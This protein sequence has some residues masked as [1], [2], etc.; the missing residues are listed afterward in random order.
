M[1]ITFGGLA[2][3]LDT[4]SIV[5]QLMAIE[6]Q[7]IDRLEKDREWFSSRQT[8]YMTFD[9]KLREFASSIKNLG[10]SDDLLQKSV[11]STSKDYVSVNATPEAL[12]GSS[13]QVEVVSL[14][15]VQKDVSRGYA[16]KMASSFGTGDLTLAVGDD[17]AV[18]I[19]I[20]ETNNSL[21]GVMQAINAADAGVSAAIINDGTDSPYRLVLTGENVATDFSL[22]SN[23]STFDGDLSSELQ[24]GGFPHEDTPLFGSGTLDLSTGDQITLSNTTNSLTDIMEA[25]NAESDTTGVT[26]EIVADGDNFVLSLSGG[27]TITATDLSGGDFVPLSLSETQAATRAHVRVDSID[28]YA[29]SNTLDEAIPGLA[30]DLLKAEEGTTTV[31]SVAVD[32]SAVKSQI[33]SFVDGYNTVASFISS[34]STINGSSG[35]ILNGDSGVNVVKRRLQNL[36]TTSIDN[37]GSFSALSQLGLKTERD[38]TLVLDDEMLT[39]AIRNNLEGVE[40]LLVGEDGS[41]GIAVKFQ[42]YLDDITDSTDGILAGTKKST[43]SNLR[44]IDNRI[45]QMEMR[46]AHREETMRAK[47]TAMESLVS[48]LNSQSDFLTQ[49]MDLLNNM[50]TGN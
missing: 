20:D 30:L 44:R 15:Q 42:D 1:S 27:A 11:T 38:G 5:E 47:Y 16:D 9:N 6:R 39:N 10:S 31:V 13:Y 2:T 32:E 33:Q 34:Q 41:D 37:S 7:P 28:I 24:S 21:Y 25:I 40:K 50:M 8:A 49:Q 22:S 14:A 46:L 36:L 48:G 3:G 12:P 26:A 17:E 23:L 18:T 4:N 45:D 35:G 43:E 19:T 29:D